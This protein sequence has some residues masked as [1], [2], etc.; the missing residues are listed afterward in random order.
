[1]WTKDQLNQKEAKKRGQKLADDEKYEDWKGLGSGFWGQLW[2]GRKIVKKNPVLGGVA[3]LQ[4]INTDA[5]KGNEDYS[6]LKAP[7]AKEWWKKPKPAPVRGM[8]SAPAYR[9]E[10]LRNEAPEAAESPAR[11]DKEP[12]V[13]DSWVER[14]KAS[15]ARII[16]HGPGRTLAEIAYDSNIARHARDSYNDVHDFATRTVP[17][18]MDRIGQGVKDTG[19]AAYGYG[20]RALGAVGSGLSGAYNI[21]KN[22]GRKVGPAAYDYGRGAYNVAK[23]AVPA[24]YDYGKRATNWLGEQDVRVSKAL[25]DITPSSVR[26][27]GGKALGGLATLGKGI[28][29]YGKKAYN[30]GKAAYNS[31]PSD[32]V[33]SGKQWLDAKDQQIKDAA[34]NAWNN[35]K[36]YLADKAKGYFK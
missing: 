3:Q 26:S 6:Y 11:G 9:Q 23:R 34:G 33:A 30:Y 27:Y 22:V 29:N 18:Y 25:N 12:E 20:K 21:A 15:P 8:P 13:A 1:M 24:A 5:I 10:E 16:D 17:D 32:P 2:H 14:A 7:V 35:T 36:S 4:K 19:N 31:M 28:Y